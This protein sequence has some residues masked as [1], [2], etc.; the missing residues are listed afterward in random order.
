MIIIFTPLEVKRTF[1][2]GVKL[3]IIKAKIYENS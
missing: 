1:F 3:N 2:I